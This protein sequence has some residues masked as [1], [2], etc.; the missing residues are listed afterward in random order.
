MNNI[1]RVENEVRYHFVIRYEKLTN[2][3][4]FII[5]NILNLL[6]V[7]CNFLIK[8]FFYLKATYNIVNPSNSPI[9][10]R[11]YLH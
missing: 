4:K 7:I 10:A 9:Q 2:D 8:H 6:F 11:E 3:H 1:S 5:Y